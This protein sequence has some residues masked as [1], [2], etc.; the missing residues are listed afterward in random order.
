MDTNDVCAVVMFTFTKF[1]EIHEAPA[2]KKKR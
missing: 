1:V 2:A